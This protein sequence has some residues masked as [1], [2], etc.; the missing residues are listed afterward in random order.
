MKV[1]VQISDGAFVIDGQNVFLYGGEFHYFRVPADQWEQR[2]DL[3]I[4]AGCNLV[5]TYVPWIWHEKREG[6][7]DLTGRT[8]KE[9][10]LAS[11]LRLV[12]EK[13]LYCIVRP[14]PYVMAE[15]RNEGIPDWLL[16]R[17]PEVIA[18]TRDGR[19]HPARVVSYMHPVFME[20]ARK[21]LGEVNRIV[22]PMQIDRGGPVIMVQLCNEIGMLHWVTN[23]SDFHPVALE[24]FREYLRERHTSIEEFN[25]EHRA[26][27]RS[28]EEL[29]DKFGRTRLKGVSLHDDWR[30]FWRRQYRQYAETLRRF[31]REDGIT[32]PVLIN[33]HGFKDYSVY[34]R[35][36]DYPVGLSQLYE[37]G[38]MPDAV[39]AGDFYPG[40]VGFDNFHD[41]V[42]ACAFTKAVSR[43]EQPLFS[44]EFQSGRLAD[45]PRV[46]PQ[47][48]DLI[49]RTCVAHGMNALN[50]YMFTA[51]SNEEGIGLFGRRHE[52]QA[53]V[54]SQGRPR[55]SYERARHLG[56]VFRVLGPQ[57]VRAAKKVHTFVGFHPDDYLMETVECGDEERWQEIAH[58]R[59]SFAFDGVWR[60][61]A[62][63][64]IQFEAVDLLNQ[65]NADQVPHL[66]V[67]SSQY[68]DEDVQRRL[69]DYV[70]QGG[71]LVLFP[72]IP[73]HDRSGRPCRVLAEELDLGEWETVTGISVVDVLGIES[74][75]CRQRLRFTRF[76]GEPLAIFTEGVKRE[77]A[78]IRKRAGG[79]EIVVLGLGMG[80]DYHYQT[81]VI[82][83][84]AGLL[85]ISA[86]L[87]ADDPHLHLVERTGDG[88]SF[89]FVM[90]YDEEERS[91]VIS[92]RGVPLFGGQRIVLP[93]RS[94]AL[95]VRKWAVAAGLE[96]EYATAEPVGLETEE[97]LVKLTVKPV[98]CHGRVCVNLAEN[99]R[100]EGE[101]GRIVREIAG[102]TAWVFERVR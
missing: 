35:G 59:D 15:L 6:E 7:A 20:K 9:R 55:P 12:K 69:A 76:E 23:T 1:A 31:A 41:L 37:T 28:W 13:G 63:A 65:I 87:E 97:N 38:Q 5:S 10:D 62:A 68:M 60:M 3:L 73:S 50:Y 85:G 99:W 26:S 11:F 100:L 19:E 57:L 72:E 22:A 45:R 53:P 2:L 77:T 91:G 66:W 16:D 92:E 80:H 89:V 51:G 14:G 36:I 17:Y 54:D 49:T 82:R 74:V 81:D 98:G 56:N 88:V 42:L 90:N 83:A 78:A 33:V 84:V 24:Q 46:V 67:F 61:L 32:V 4:Q 18:R 40:R 25:R 8:R 94:G 71:K 48:L 95:F 21:W 43:P 47:D 75:M 64:N 44:A 34:S 96:I 102:E 70:K 93:P 101:T 39:L 52:W 30:K 29:V 27:F 86:H 79:G 58:K